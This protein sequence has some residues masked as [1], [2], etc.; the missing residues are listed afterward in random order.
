MGELIEMPGKR[1][2]DT[3]CMFAVVLDRCKTDDPYPHTLSI[4]AGID[5]ADAAAAAYCE[6]MADGRGAHVRLITYD[7]VA[8]KNALTWH[9]R[10]DP[11]A[12]SE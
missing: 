9:D 11:A 5:D 7:L 6:R 1:K 8:F 3:H 2:V 4:H 12:V 10:P